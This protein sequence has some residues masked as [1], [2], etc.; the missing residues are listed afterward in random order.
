M[1]VEA[2]EKAN[3]HREEHSDGCASM[4]IATT[5]VV[6]AGPT[7]PDVGPSRVTTLVTIIGVGISPLRVAEGVATTTL[8]AASV[9]AGSSVLDVFVNVS[10]WSEE[11][12]TTG[13]DM[14]NL[15]SRWFWWWLGIQE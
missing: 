8:V 7:L 4:V 10:A 2:A 15:H 5:S 1:M 11:A 6:K 3:A 14:M 9:V 12:I 13:K